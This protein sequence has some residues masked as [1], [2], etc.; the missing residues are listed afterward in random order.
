MVCRNCCP[1]CAA[2]ESQRYCSVAR[3]IGHQ[4]SSSTSR[5]TQVRSTQIKYVYIQYIFI[6]VFY[7]VIQKIIHPLFR[8][9]ITQPDRYDLALLLLSR[10]A[11]L[12]AHV[13]PV[14]LPSS[15]WNSLDY[16]NVTKL[17]NYYM[18]ITFIVHKFA[19]R[20]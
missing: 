14:C 16:N 3:C 8:Y 5:K 20:I 18:C 17:F 1:L 7:R 13:L 19:F 12:G 4:S 11:V 10:P 6:C 9:R 15:T 2:S